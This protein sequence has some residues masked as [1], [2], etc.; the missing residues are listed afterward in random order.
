MVTRSQNNI[1][2]P[3]PRH[4]H[5]TTKHVIPCPIEPACVSQ[6]SKNKEWRDAMNGTWT[7]VPPNK[8]QNVIGN[9]W[10]YRTKKKANGTVERFKARLVTKGFY[11]CLGID[12]KDTFSPVIKPK[13]IQTVLCV[14]LHNGWPLKQLDVN[15]A[16]LQGKLTEEVHMAQPVGFI[17]KDHPDYVCQ[18][19]KAISGLKQA[20]RAW[21]KELSSFLLEFSFHNS[22]GDASLF[23]YKE[24]S[25]IIYF[26]V[27]VDDLIVTGNNQDFVSKFV[28]QLSQRF[29]LKDVGNLHFF[30]GVEVIPTKSRLFLSQHKYMRD[31][32]EKFH[33]AEAKEVQTP[34]A[35]N[36][37]LKLNDGTGYVDATKYRQLIGSLQ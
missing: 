30:L 16:F 11:Q 15:N 5:L 31:V 7:L 19:Q 6:A 32:L 23:I 13:T 18:L 17:D 10:V 29:S 25:H 4:S 21:Y 35:T 14:A 27:Y 34:L 1:H 3:N 20:F 2:K 36:V 8:K 24:Q 37:Q 26:L 33:M 28:A 22:I 12:F 9:K